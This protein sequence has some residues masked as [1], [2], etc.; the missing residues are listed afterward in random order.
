MSCT[1]R[2]NFSLWYE[3]CVTAVF[4]RKTVTRASISVSV[5]KTWDAAAPASLTFA[6]HKALG[7]GNSQWDKHN[8]RTLITW[9]NIARYINVND[10]QV[11]SVW[12]VK[13]ILLISTTK[14]FLW[15]AGRRY[16]GYE[17]VWTP[18][19]NGRFVTTLILRILKGL[20]VQVLCPIPVGISH[21]I[22]TVS[23]P[24]SAS[25]TLADKPY[26]TLMPTKLK[27]FTYTWLIHPCWSRV[28]F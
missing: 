4:Y 16:T 9:H 21:Q 20:R 6:V 15:G 17:N 1:A 23:G 24:S 26:F 5:R 18:Y 19:Q 22:Q 13:W 14:C 2:L 7:D 10:Q 11:W 28:A 12:I 25:F 3:P 27:P 8:K